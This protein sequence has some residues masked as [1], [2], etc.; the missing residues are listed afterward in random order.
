M[1]APQACPGEGRSSP[2]LS[3]EMMK[4]MGESH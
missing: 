1:E 2:E 4:N 3:S